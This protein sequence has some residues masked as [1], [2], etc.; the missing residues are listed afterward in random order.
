[1]DGYGLVWSGLVWSGLVWSGLVWP[2]TIRYRL[3]PCVLP[4]ESCKI[5][6]FCLFSSSRPRKHPPTVVPQLPHTASTNPFHALHRSCTRH[7]RSLDTA[8]QAPL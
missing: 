5:R 8:R 7:A 2:G 4:T 1:M 6:C 3:L